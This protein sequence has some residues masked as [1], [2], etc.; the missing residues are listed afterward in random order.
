MARPTITIIKATGERER[1]DPMKLARSVRRSGVQRQLAR[2]TAAHVATRI[3][4]GATTQQIHGLVC[5][6]LNRCHER[7]AAARYTLKDAMRRLGPAGYDFEKFIAAVLREYGY[8]AD[9]PDLI[10]GMCVEH[11]VDVV[12]RKDGEVAMAECKYRNEAGIHVRLK[13]IMA[14]WARYEDLREAF[15]KRRHRI[16]FTQCW[17]VCNTKI[18]SD[19]TAFG[20]C[21]GMRLIGWQQPKEAGLERMIEERRLYPITVLSAITSTMQVQFARAGIM[22]C[23]D[24]TTTEPAELVRR[25]G[26]PLPAI[27]RI[28][29]EAVE[30]LQY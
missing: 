25:T 22:L 2:E 9:L 27:M 16:P 6:Y 14:T 13:D 10:P 19:G 8:E 11:E 15:A 24:L 4:D 23:S 21:K 3:R 7:G 18:T 28:R 29:Q 20:Q 30:A 12:A 26:V 5:R 17:M 1:F